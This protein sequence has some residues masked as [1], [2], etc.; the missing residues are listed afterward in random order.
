[1]LIPIVVVLRVAL[2][3]GIR[4]AEKRS[5]P[6][7]NRDHWLRVRDTIYEEIQTKGWNSEAQIYSQS[8]ES[9][10]ILDSSVL[11]MP[12]VFFMNASDP[13][14][15]STLQN[16]LKTFE[17]GGLSESIHLFKFLGKC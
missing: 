8:Y 5:L 4:L 13:R 3:R 10:T 14:F 16:I 9:P 12:L 11:I 2:D 6:A 17:N 7:P 1:M 15:L